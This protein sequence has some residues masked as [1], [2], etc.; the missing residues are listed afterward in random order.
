MSNGH[1]LILGVACQIPTWFMVAHALG[2]YNVN[3]WAAAILVACLSLL[4]TQGDN[5]GCKVAADMRSKEN[6]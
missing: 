6:E 3:G 1:K 4:Y 5:L 2:T